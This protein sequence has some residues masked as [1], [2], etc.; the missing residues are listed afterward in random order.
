[1]D[2]LRNMSLLPRGLRYKFMI[3]FCLMSVIPL[4][5]A[6]YLVRDSLFPPGDDIGSIS[7]VLLFCL[8]ISILGM[9]L[10]KQIIESVIEISIDAKLIASGQIHRRVAVDADDELGDLSS[11]INNLTV[12]IK[13]KIDEL[14]SYGEKTELINTKIHQ[15]VLALS[16]LLQI[17]E[18]ISISSSLEDVMTLIIQKAAQVL[19]IE[20]ALLLLPK[21]ADPNVLEVNIAHNVKNEAL[22]Q[23]TVSRG[24]GLL[25]TPVGRGEIVTP[26]SSSSAV[27]DDFRALYGIR[28]FCALPIL[29][30]GNTVGVL[31]VGSEA[32]G[33]TFSGDTVEILKV[34][35][36][37]AAIAYEN[38]QLS[39]R[40]KALA[41]K[42]DLTDLFNKNYIARRLEEEIRR[43]ILYQRPC[44]YV[45]FNID[46]FSIF[47]GKNGELATERALK[48]IALVLKENV[49]QIGRAARLGGDEFALLLPEKNKREA[50]R[51]A[52]DVR[53]KVESL[54]LELEQPM[55]LTISAGVSENP[56]DGATS[57]DLMAKAHSSLESAKNQGKNRVV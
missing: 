54:D 24:E 9:I 13:D 8:V 25:A 31:L 4:L 44:S 57:E 22:R 53:K 29:A 47:R 15:N 3:A 11:A 30:E 32:E 12:N 2:I 52:E 6:V 26:D 43:S 27:L 36:K 28:N 45:I 39:R 48:K 46:D 42:D 1:M 16:S 56:L 23:I 20:Y 51:I 7:L 49:T 35:A 18:S 17:G 41:V 21:P 5:V 34:F 37:Q 14:K 19:D 38:D 10:A 50:F 33:Y 55:R 40:S